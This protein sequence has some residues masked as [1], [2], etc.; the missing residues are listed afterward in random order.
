MS[1]KVIKAKSNQS[2]VSPYSFKTFSKVEKGVKS[3][4]FKELYT[5]SEQNSNINQASSDKNAKVN[6]DVVNVEEIKIAEKKGYDKGFQEGYKKG[7]DEAEKLLKSR[8]EAEKNDYL[9]LLKKNF[10]R[11]LNEIEEVKKHFQELDENLP[12]L[13]VK[14]VTEIIGVERKINDTIIKS[15]ISNILSKIKTY[16][17]VT[18]IVCPEDKKILEEMN[19]GYSIETDPNLHKGDLKVKTNL[20]TIDFSINNLIEEFKERLYEEFESS[21]EN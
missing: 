13:I 19:L 5:E 15:I 3:Y 11:A 6:V 21:K 7:K 2:R 16:T 10:Q 18:F 12:D 17:D 8:Y 14:F 4:S 20:G 1:R 9:D